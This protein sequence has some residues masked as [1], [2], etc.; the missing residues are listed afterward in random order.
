METCPIIVPRW[1]IGLT[2][3]SSTDALL[4]G[5][6][7]QHLGV[8]VP[9]TSLRKELPLTDSTIYD[10][11][12]RLRRA[13]LVEKTPDGYYRSLLNYDKTPACWDGEDN[14]PALELSSPEEQPKKKR[15]SRPT[16]EEIRSY[17]DSI[18]YTA[19]DADAF[20]DYYEALGWSIS[21]KPMKDWQATVRNWQRREASR[22]ARPMQAQPVQQKKA[23][24]PM[25]D[26]MNYL[27]SLYQQ[28]QPVDEQIW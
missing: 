9:A 27:K 18:G 8:G 24:T 14:A 11:L 21:G 5:A 26:G 7:L 3:L 10:S 4:F 13:N 6:V 19:L 1:V 12:T 17:A 15:F 23:Y 28:P 20:Y 25:V 16:V 2:Q 22:P